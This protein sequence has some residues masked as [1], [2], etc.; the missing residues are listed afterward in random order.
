M[1]V[2]EL[3]NK[4]K[5]VADPLARDPRLPGRYTPSMAETYWAVRREWDGQGR[6]YT[7]LDVEDEVARRLQPAPS[8]FAKEQP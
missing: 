4:P 7:A 2:A 3:F 5:P 6:S 8:L 1:R